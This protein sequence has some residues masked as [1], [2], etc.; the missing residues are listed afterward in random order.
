ML[1]AL[2]TATFV[3]LS[4]ARNRARCEVRCSEDDGLQL[5]KELC[6]CEAIPV[7]ATTCDSGFEQKRDCSCQDYTVY[8]FDCRSGYVGDTTDCSC[9][10][11][12]EDMTY[13]FMCHDDYAL[14]TDG[15]CACNFTGDLCDPIRC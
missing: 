1:K 2:L 8:D 10:K 15:T 5:N 13:M 3:A 12:S 14:A 11:E 4:D 6:A 9:Y 7:C